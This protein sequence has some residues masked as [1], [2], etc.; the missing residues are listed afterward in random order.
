ML[1]QILAITIK[2]LK[3]LTRDRAGMITLFAMP[4][5]F[6]L[7]MSVALQSAFQV[8]GDD[9]PIEL[10]VVNQDSGATYIEGSEVSLAEDA[11]RALESFDGLRLFSSEEGK[12]LTRARAEALIADGTYQMAL[13]FPDDFSQRVV[14]SLSDPS[15]EQP[16]LIFVIDPTAGT[17]LVAPVEAAVRATVNR[18]AAYAQAPY[19]IQEALNAVG[20]QFPAEQQMFVAQVGQALTR[21]L[22]E[23]YDLGAISGQSE[24]GLK[25][26]Y[27]LSSTWLNFR[28]R[29]SKMYP[30][31]RYS[32]SSLSLAF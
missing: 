28:T 16:R 8:G 31:M 5:M 29:S 1:Q 13:V 18:T 22:I 3:I 32:V 9:N 21:Q 30:D 19:R 26:Q 6:I 12:A 11:I 27:L 10:L 14:D 17:Q 25:K 4:L 7:V 20:S 24:I 15:V 2:D 23:T